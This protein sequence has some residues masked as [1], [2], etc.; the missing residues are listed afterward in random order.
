MI[1]RVIHYCWF[2][3]QS[4]PPIVKKRI[5]SWIKY[6]PD[7]EIK[8]WDEKNFD[9]FQNQYARE[10]FELKKWAFVSDYARLK[11][12][13]E[14]GG[15]YLDTD[16]ELIKPLDE[17]LN[18]AFFLAIEKDTNVITNEESIHVATGLG[19]G[20]GKENNVIGAMLKEY[21]D[22]H[23]ITQSG[24]DS[25]PCPVRNT[26]AL[27]QFGYIDINTL[28]H[29]EGGS[30]YP[31]TYFCPIEFSNSHIKN[32]SDRTISIHHYDASWKSKKEKLFLT[33]F[34]MKRMLVRFLSRDKNV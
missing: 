5:R 19:F 1:P 32:T 23:F 10:A 34:K 22:I 4:E 33:L 14:Y 30:V 12:V 20:A 8:R 25:T 9:V 16:V 7:Y 13:Y 17:V 3:G 28:Q 26:A 21:D 29:F 24:V 6:C 2:G 27:Y 18:N 31:A 11:I 15:I